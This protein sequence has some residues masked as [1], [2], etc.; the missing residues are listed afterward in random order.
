MTITETTEF[1]EDEFTTEAM[2][3]ARRQ[4]WT[5]PEGTISELKAQLAAIAPHREPQAFFRQLGV[6][7]NRPTG[8]QMTEARRLSRNEQVNTWRR[9][10]R[11]QAAIDTR[12][13]E[14]RRRRLA[15][16]A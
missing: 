14:A 7:R 2:R 15:K 12:S 13:A 9:K 3:I 16:A 10:T 8:D 5:L 4:G 1:I 6:K 11:I